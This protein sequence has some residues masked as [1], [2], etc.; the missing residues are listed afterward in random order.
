MAKR[1]PTTTNP[2][3]ALV[4]KA[5]EIGWPEFYETD[6]TVHD[7]AKLEGRATRLPFIWFVRSAGTWLLTAEGEGL[8][9]DNNGKGKTH[10]EI[11]LDHVS[12]PMN[13]QHRA[14]FWDGEKLTELTKDKWI[15]TYQDKV[16]ARI[17]RYKVR[18]KID[19]K[20]APWAST[21]TEFKD[22]VI[23]WSG[24]TE[25][26]KDHVLL[27]HKDDSIKDRIVSVQIQTAPT[28]ERYEQSLLR[29]VTDGH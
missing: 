5:E 22:A 24:D 26:L 25:S 1:T 20:P 8:H 18:V 10:D 4:A 19:T 15:K 27:Y 21:R 28:H 17:P 29:G 2:Y 23:S 16:F 3:D 6:L 14:F 7:K 9:R 11:L 13:S 12:N